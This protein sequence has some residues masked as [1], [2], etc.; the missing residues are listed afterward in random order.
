MPVIANPEAAH[1][2]TLFIPISSGKWRPPWRGKRHLP[3]RGRF[4]QDNPA[5]NRGLSGAP[6]RELLQETREIR[7][8]QLRV[9]RAPVAVGVRVPQ[10]V[11]LEEAREIGDV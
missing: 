7:H 8:V 5:G 11:L 9:P 6:L 2:A 10:V 3:S 1:S 4:Q